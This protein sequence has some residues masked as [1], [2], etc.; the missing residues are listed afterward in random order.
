MGESNHDATLVTNKDINV[1]YNVIQK[2]KDQKKLIQTLAKS[3]PQAKHASHKIYENVSGRNVDDVGDVKFLKKRNFRL[4]D[5]NKH[6]SVPTSVTTIH[7]Q[8][9]DKVMNVNSKQVKPLEEEL[10]NHFKGSSVPVGYQALPDPSFINTFEPTDTV[11]QPASPSE[12]NRILMR[13]SDMNVT[14][15]D[16]NDQHIV[17]SAICHGLALSSLSG[18]LPKT[19]QAALSSKD[20]KLWKEACLKELSAFYSHGTFDLVPLPKDRRALGSRWVF[21]EKSGGVKKS[22]LVAQGHTQKAGIDYTETFAPVVRYESV[23]VYLTIAASL[24]LTIHQMDVDTAFLNSELD[25]DVYVKQPPGFI[26]TKHPDWVWKLKKGMYGLKQAPLL[27]NHH[28]H[29]TLSKAKFIRHDGDYGIYFK[30]TTEG[31][32]LIALYVDDLLIAAP[33]PKAMNFAKRILSTTYSMKDLG[34]VNKFLGMTIH[35][36]D[37][38]ITLDLSDYI[39]NSAHELG[40]PLNKQVYTPLV[41]IGPLFDSSSPLVQNATVYRSIVGQL[42]FAANAARPDIAYAVSV[43]SRFLQNPRNNHMSAAVKVLQYLYCTRQ[44][45]LKYNIGDPLNLI[46]YADASSASSV[47]LSYSTGGYV[48]LLAGGIVTWSSKKIKTEV[49]L[50]STEAEYISAS[51]AVKEIEWLRNLLSFID[52]KLPV[53]K[54]YVDNDPAIKLA[55]HPVFHP[56]T[57][58]IALHYHKI[59]DMVVKQ[60]V[61]I[62]YV[63]TNE[64]LADIFTKALARAKFEK[65]RHQLLV[66]IKK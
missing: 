59:R 38:S 52:I 4:S 32:L 58:H 15:N 37:T 41:D 20:A 11:H 29:A 23:R 66:E 34:K 7:D 9:I 14:K 62:N 6:V 36:S 60:I 50:S 35:Q 13:H 5:L 42:L 24:N 47:D 49:C 48:T 10:I 57:K 51:N 1:V 39:M 54:L 30:H 45:G 16:S 46:V 65:F 27:W 43:L 33:T 17:L 61:E 26:S 25:E 21:T 18:T 28:I 55:K 64:Q 12:S 8:V 63:P 19:I 53:T 40:I 56:R 22:R 44:L 31:L 3:A 2:V